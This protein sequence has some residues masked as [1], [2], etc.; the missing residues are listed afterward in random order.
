MGLIKDISKVINSFKTHPVFGT[1]DVNYDPLEFE[2]T[3]E[4]GTTIIGLC[5]DCRVFIGGS[6][7]TKDID[8]VTINNKMDGN[9]CNIILQNPRG[10]YEISKFDLMKKWREDKDVLAAYNY[11]DF[12]RKD[13][14]NFDK[15]AQKIGEGVFGPKGGKLVGESIDMIRQTESVL[16]SISSF[17]GGKPSIKGTT[18]ML[19]ETKFASGLI[20][21]VGDCVFDYRDPVYVFMKGRFSPYWYFAFSGIV[22]SY[23]DTNNYGEVSAITLKCEDVASLWKRTR[24]MKKGAFYGMSNMENATLNTSANSASNFYTDVSGGLSFSKM[25]K[26]VAFSYDYG[27]K[28]INSHPCYDPITK[29]YIDPNSDKGTYYQYMNKLRSGAKMDSNFMVTDAGMLQTFANR[30]GNIPLVGKIAYGTIKQSDIAYSNYNG[31]PNGDPL[32]AAA[33]IYLQLNFIELQRFTGD[34]IVK[35]LALSARYWEF[36]HQVDKSFDSLRSKGTGWQ[37]TKAFGVCGT[38]PALKYEFI[39]N[40]NILEGVWSQIYSAKNIDSLVMTPY[41]KIMEPIVGSPTERVTENSF[42]D[43][44]VGTNFNLF[45]PR[46]FVLLPQ[47]YNNNKMLESAF[48]APGKIFDSDST[49]IADFFKTK[50]KA[51]EYNYYT[52]PMGDIFIEPELYDFHPTDFS[53][54]IEAR[55]IVTKSENIGFK[56]NKIAEEGNLSGT[57]LP[58][59]VQDKA[60]FFNPDANH[61]FFIMEK[62]RIQSSF[63]FSPDNIVSSVEVLGGA[64]D[65]GGVLD[66]V[67]LGIA[68]KA[69][70]ALGRGSATPAVGNNMFAVGTYVANGFEAY[71]KT[72]GKTIEASSKKLTELNSTYKK[73]LFLDLITG[74][75]EKKLKDIVSL[76]ITAVIE[77]STKVDW[78]S[79]ITSDIKALVARETDTEKQI[80]YVIEKYVSAIFT[81]ARKDYKSLVIF[82]MRDKTI[83]EILN[84]SNNDYSGST[85]ETF[86]LAGDLNEAYKTA[87]DKALGVNS[88]P[89]SATSDTNIQILDELKKYEN[90]GLFDLDSKGTESILGMNRSLVFQL[91]TIY[92][93][94]LIT[95]NDIA[96]KMYLEVV[97]LKDKAILPNQLRAVTIQD[98]KNYQRRGFYD[99]RTDLVRQ[100]GYKTIEPIKNK[101]IRS[102]VESTEYA[103]AVFNRLLGQAN[104]VE[105]VIIGRPELMLNRPYY[106]ERKDCIGLNTGYTIN[107]KYGGDFN[108]N[109]SLTYIRKNALTY[110][111]SLNE[112]DVIEAGKNKYFSNEGDKYL[113]WNKVLQQGASTAGASMNQFISGDS[114]SKT[115]GILGNIAGDATESLINSF[116]PI[117]GIFTAHGRLGHIPFDSRGMYKN[118]TAASITESS[119]I[120]FDEGIAEVLTV[121]SN[122][123]KENLEKRDIVT[124]KIITL[125][126]KLKQLETDRENTY[127]EED[128]LQDEIALATSQTDKAILLNKYTTADED[129]AM[130]TRTID[131]IQFDI[132]NLEN[133]RY[134]IYYKLYGSQVS[135]Y[136][137]VYKE[138][139]NK[140]IHDNYKVYGDES[141]TKSGVFFALFYNFISNLTSVKLQNP[142]L[143]DIKEEFGKTITK[144]NNVAY[145]IKRSDKTIVT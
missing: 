128:I 59:I 78:E 53:G 65:V 28:A 73:Y 87:R 124:Y 99:P 134:L 57:L 98:L 17:F 66:S 45:R 52:S 75:R 2:R 104:K 4:D 110:S 138:D 125:L 88:T 31:G 63:T 58:V 139:L 54:K 89:E 8:S 85:S 29:K 34:D 84:F 79:N 137:N 133:E 108:S 142:L 82:D 25:V 106:F 129:I 76:F 55:S 119:S 136:F 100:Y 93:P 117:G 115:T 77:L 105:T 1:F 81:A 61:P 40:F 14:L 27:L 67:P 80:D 51:V 111:Y 94:Y 86:N 50:L 37:N 135:N 41:D 145:Y 47:R 102:G 18:R 130:L 20:R 46:L 15:L 126:D 5:P 39:D 64:T 21:R 91:L 23:G 116:G 96:G 103:Y 90:A 131:S 11:T 56:E 113:R 127:N 10:R 69:S 3:R 114:T 49:T 71:S 118:Y 101:M 68:Q 62:D 143:W 92:E 44:P 48:G 6:E 132:T 120:K 35:N 140:F 33:S 42:S 72:A 109:V 97:A 26:I 32:S 95:T 7:V 22:K 112:L 70:T 122:L 121:Y 74:N 16:G 30:L 43:K 83:D 123:I 19:F 13:P 38:H 9:E 141:I 107:Y 60:Y 12:D 144:D 24:F 36:G